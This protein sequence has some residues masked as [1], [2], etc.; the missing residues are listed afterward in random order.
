MKTVLVEFSKKQRHTLVTLQQLIA[1]KYLPFCYNN[2]SH[3]VLPELGEDYL[4]VYGYAQTH[5]TLE[6][7]LD[8]WKAHNVNVRLNGTPPLA[9]C[10]IDMPT[11]FWNTC[12]G[13]V[14][15]MKKVIGE[16]MANHD[17]T[18]ESVLLL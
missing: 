11:M 12:M 16:V 3:V 5:E 4:F 18:C 14:D 1:G 6:L 13:N 8:I 7:W 2:T 10:F 15:T 9:R 17:G